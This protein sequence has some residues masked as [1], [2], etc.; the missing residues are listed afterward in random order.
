[1]RPRFVPLAVLALGCSNEAPDPELQETD[2]I[3]WVSQ[4]RCLSPCAYDPSPHLASVDRF[5][6]EVEDGP[7]RFSAAARPELE[8]LLEAAK[9]DGRDIGFDSAYRSYAEQREIYEIATE[10]GRAA[11]PGHSEHQT[12]ECVDFEYGGPDDAAWLAEHAPA[13]GFVLSYPDGKQ[14]I[15]GYRYEP[16]HYRFVGRER[17]EIVAA[18]GLSLE[19]YFRDNPEEGIS[20]DCSDCPSP[21]SLPEPCGDVPEEGRCE[22]SVLTFCQGGARLSVDC[23]AWGRSCAGGEAGY[24]CR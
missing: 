9:A 16:W 5:G 1:M 11:R 17:A 10:P 23:A 14:K 6:R 8:A 21:L 22:G 18:R 13:F 3:F 4:T 19:E 15:T 12:G 20:G 24:D 7:F 2:R